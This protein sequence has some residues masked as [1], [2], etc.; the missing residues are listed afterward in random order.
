MTKPDSETNGLPT[1]D[2]GG[3]TPVEGTV[4][5]AGQPVVA[6]ADQAEAPAVLDAKDESY[7]GLVD[8]MYTGSDTY[9]KD[10]VTF[11]PNEVKTVGAPDARGFLSDGDSF[12][13]V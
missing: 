3:N 10:G 2:L 13:V 1:V 8:I 9:S 7:Q 12:T 6:A 4:P 5:N 11:A